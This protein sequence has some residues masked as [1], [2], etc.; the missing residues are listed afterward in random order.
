VQAGFASAIDDDPQVVP[1]GQDGSFALVK[2]E[3]IVPPAA[4]PLA[5]VQ[6]DVARQFLTDR[7]LRAARQ[8]AVKIVQQ[9]NG[10]TP[11]AQAL[12]GANVSGA[13]IEPVNATR[14]QLAA[15]GQ[16]LPPPIT[17]MFS[18][19]A[20]KAKLVE[21]PDKSGYFV[22]FL[23]QIENGDASKRL[24]V[25][26]SARRGMGGVVGRELSDQFVEA[27]SRE[28]KVKRDAAAV[29]R[30]RDELSGQASGG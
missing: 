22:V 2:L 14:A 20:K 27:F 17:L 26:A 12:Q 28:L 23:D 15:T 9:V 1:L 4:R 8:A 7:A 3:R 19:A 21:A 16:Q 30:V 25:V 29:K 11:L 24:D 10:G 13:K 6:N 18:M 5:A